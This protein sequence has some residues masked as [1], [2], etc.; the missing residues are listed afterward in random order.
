[1]IVVVTPLCFCGQTVPVGI[2]FAFV[3][4]YTNAETNTGFR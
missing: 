2:P 3:I 4:Y 1:M